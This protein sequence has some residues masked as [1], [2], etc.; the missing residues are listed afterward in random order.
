MKKTTNSQIAKVLGIPKST[1]G[2]YTTGRRRMTYETAKRIELVTK[3][4]HEFLISAD[5]DHVVMAIKAF[6]WGKE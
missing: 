3:M 5:R 2:M 1:W 4:D 6:C